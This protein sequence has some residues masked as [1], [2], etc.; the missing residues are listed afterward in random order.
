[1]AIEPTINVYE[2]TPTPTIN[3]TGQTGTIAVIGAFNSEITSVTSVPTVKNAHTLFGTSTTYGTFK[4]TDVI[5]PLFTGA[6]SLLIV[7]TTTWTGSG[8]EKTAETTLTNQKLTDALTLLTGE[9]FDILF[10]A[11][12]L[13]DEA[14]TIVSTWLDNEHKNKNPHGQVA[15]FTRANANAYTNSIPKFQKNL[16]Y[17]NTQILTINGETLD[18]NRS[19]A[20]ICGLIVGRDLLSSLTNKTIPNV[21]GI[22]PEYSTTTGELGATLLS[23]NIPFLKCRNRRENKY[24]CVNSTLP[25]GFDLY[26]NRVR[27]Y[28][29]RRIEIETF[30]GDINSDKALDGISNVVESVKYDVINKMKLLTDIVYSVE[31]ESSKCVNV[32]LEKLVFN[33]VIAEINIYYSIEVE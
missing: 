21:T 24:I 6:S 12:D 25:N 1:M 30:L 14:Q 27:D 23:L 22:T 15:N 13:T 19:S 8:N 28:I 5:D 18:L 20:Y 7:N 32:L 17:P 29:I 26:I 3:N 11:E 10:V 9:E 33:D 2:E 4:G 16:Y 31:K